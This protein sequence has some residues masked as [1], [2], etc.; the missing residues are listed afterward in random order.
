MPPS[1]RVLL[2]LIASATLAAGAAFVACVD[3]G[4][5]PPAA[6]D[7]GD[8]GANDAPVATDDASSD[9]AG[10]AV[11]D[12]GPDIEQDPD[13]YPAKHQ[14][15]AQID[16]LGGP[17]LD[18][19]K[20]VTVTFQGD[21]RRDDLY[22][23][24]DALVTSAFWHAT[25]A[26]YGI[27]DGTS[28]GHIE[29]PDTV[30]GKD[31]TDTDIQNL[32]LANIAS[33]ALPAPDAQTLYVLYYPASTTILFG[34]GAALGCVDFLAYHSSFPFSL[35]GG[36]SSSELVYATVARCS[37]STPADT[38]MYLT[39]G[40]SHAIAE[41]VTNPHAFSAPGYMLVTNDAWL[42]SGGSTQNNEL[43]DLCGIYDVYDAGWAVQLLWSNAAA[44][45][46]KPP[47]QP[48][49]AGQI[50]FGAAV[51]TTLD[52]IGGRKSYGYVTL[53]PGQ[54]KDVVVDV[55]S[56]APLPNELSLYVGRPR[57]GTPRMMD[58][59]PGGIT[60][61][62]SRATAHNGNGVVLTVT[63]PTSTAV[64]DYPFAVRALL[65]DNTFQ[66]WPVIAHVK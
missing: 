13:V 8:D 31:V 49:P 17:L 36:P 63:V 3:D 62:L 59:I 7:G 15:L 34:N 51:R 14:P 32:L 45:S 11:T 64:G 12:A 57:P 30:S 54:S 35:D 40:A 5:Q 21:V 19:V 22:A 61:S 44:S 60:A 1:K 65:D 56:G 28:G 6:S 18:H 25:V 39:V 37:F 41:A 48:A 47:C 29:L 38:A 4:A 10:D 27:H 50:G 23:F 2:V 9:A 16:Y 53:A 42:R 58:V 24:D 46:S 43:G 52:L 20:I 66:D 33:G 26:E 55:F